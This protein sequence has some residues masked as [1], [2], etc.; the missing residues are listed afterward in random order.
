MILRILG[1]LA[2]TWV[3]L[4][5]LAWIFQRTFIYFPTARSAPPA[6]AFFD[7]GQDV[8]F[9]TEDGIRLAGWFVPG[10]GDSGR[11]TVL[12][13]NGNAGDRSFRAPLAQALN[14]SG[15][16]V[17]LFDYRGYGG[18]LGSPSEGGLLADARAAREYVAWREDVD[19]GRMVYYGESL[20]SAVAVRLAAEHPPAA[21]VLRS[22]FTSIA[23]VG[24]VHYPFLPVRSLLRD[25]FSC[26]DRISSL[27]CPLLVLAG[28]KDSIV[29]STQSRRIFDA[30]REPKRFVLIPGAD[31]NGLELFAGDRL[32]AEVVRFVEETT[33]AGGSRLGSTSTAAP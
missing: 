14:R 25:R 12:V 6:R 27:A 2:A 10:G 31:H 30:A 8:A 4:V 20:G 33:G 5:G 24:R 11:T 18:N 13:F 19:P 15:F 28:E 9:E 1:L 21:M 32:V 23:D 29:P 16:S 3:L 7:G 22:P 17:L 26:V